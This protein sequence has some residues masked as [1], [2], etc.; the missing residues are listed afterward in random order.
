MGR[1][2]LIVG[3]NTAKVTEFLDSDGNDMCI[4]LSENETPVYAPINKGTITP[5]PLQ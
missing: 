2:Y 5:K 3:E 1:L 4:Q